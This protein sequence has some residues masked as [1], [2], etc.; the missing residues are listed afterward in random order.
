M[1][2]FRGL[3]NTTLVPALLEESIWN[4]VA[5]AVSELHVARVHRRP[6][7]GQVVIGIMGNTYPNHSRNSYFRRNSTLYFV[8]AEG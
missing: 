3:P 8:G 2:P 4:C 7:E 1:G 6:A 5:A